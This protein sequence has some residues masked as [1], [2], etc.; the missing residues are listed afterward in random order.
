MA[1]KLLVLI[2]EVYVTDRR[3]LLDALKPLI[4]DDR[5]EFQPKGVDQVTAENR[6]NFI[7]TSNHKDAI[8]KTDDD[9]RYAIFYTAQQAYGDLARDG[10]TE[11]Y[12]TTFWQWMNSGGYAN[13]AGYLQRYAIPDAL[14]PATYCN[15]APHT[16]ST[17][18]AIQ[19]SR[20]VVEQEIIA[21]VEEGRPGFCGG[22]ISSVRLTQLLTELRRNVAPRKRRALME[23]IGYVP[24]PALPNGQVNTPI[25][26]EEMK[27]PVLYVR[28]DSIPALN[29]TE[30]GEAVYN[31]MN[32]Q[33][34]GAIK[35]HSV[36]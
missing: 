19:E 4:T 28:R 33:G 12:F 36:P 6:A 25:M 35:L 23:S 3:E 2:E 8:L 29:I 17:D 14:N 31:Y 15:R 34:Y 11:S 22:W 1:Q 26:Q 10:L 13:V 24:H 5:V 16:S 9:R 18:A 27:R 30:G 20:G 32:A 7:L 21:A